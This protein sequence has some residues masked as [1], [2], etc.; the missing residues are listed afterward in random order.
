MYAVAYTCS[1]RLHTRTTYATAYT[2]MQR[3]PLRTCSTVY[4]AAYVY[5]PR[6]CAW[7]LV[8]SRVQRCIVRFY[9]PSYITCTQWRTHVPR[10]RLRTALRIVRGC[11]QPIRLYAM[12]YTIP[13]GYYTP[14]GYHVYAAAYTLCNVGASWHRMYAAAYRDGT[15]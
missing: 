13:G 10:T 4:A 9:A 3:T 5:N 1:I 12:A 7:R 2:A 8:R 6:A 14:I 15:P 11:V